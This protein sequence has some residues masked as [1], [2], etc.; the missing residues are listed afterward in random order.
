MVVFVKENALYY[1]IIGVRAWTSFALQISCCYI[2]GEVDNIPRVT[3]LFENISRVD[4]KS[5]SFFPVQ[6]ILNETIL[7]MLLKYNR[8]SNFTRTHVAIQA[9]KQIET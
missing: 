4:K 6:H 3:R 1:I 9:N 7:N 5:E 8:N 2:A